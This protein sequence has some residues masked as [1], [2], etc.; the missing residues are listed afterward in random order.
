MEDIHARLYSYSSFIHTGD[1]LNI[2]FCI[3]IIVY[4]IYFGECSILLIFLAT[5]PMR[6][7]SYAC[8]CGFSLLK[9]IDELDDSYATYTQSPTLHW[10][11]YDKALLVPTN[12]CSSSWWPETVTETE[13]ST[14]FFLILSAN[15][16]IVFFFYDQSASAKINHPA[17]NQHPAK[18]NHSVGGRCNPLCYSTPP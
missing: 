15:H 1:G 8:S 16:S 3:N 6:T 14:A 4:Y 18:I 12:K 10:W 17:T 9:S 5:M 13:R 7:R 2:H 11:V